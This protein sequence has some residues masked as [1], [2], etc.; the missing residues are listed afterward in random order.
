MQNGKSPVVYGMPC[1][2]YKVMWENIGDDFIH[3]DSKAF[4]LGHLIESINQ[5]LI[6]IIPRNAH[7][8][9]IGD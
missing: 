2:F 3:L 7:K 6:N 4:S 8:D 5:G 1:K 9:T